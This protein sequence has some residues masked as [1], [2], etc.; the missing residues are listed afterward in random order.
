MTVDFSHD[1]GRRF[2][3]KAGAAAAL[4]L[5]FSLNAYAAKGGVSRSLKGNPDLESWIRIDEQG[6]V[7]IFTGKIELGQGIGTALVQIAADELDVDVGKISLITP[8]TD[9][10]PDERYTVGS[11]SIQQSGM[12]MRQASAVARA[13]L[14]DWAAEDLK[15]SASKLSIS[16]GVISSGSRK[17][18][19]GELVAARGQ[20]TGN[21]LQSAPVKKPADRT[22]SGTSMQRRDIPGKIFAEGVYI[23]DLR[24]P[25]MMHARVVRPATAGSHLKSLDKAAV[26]KMPGVVKIVQD[27]SFLAVIA[28]R[29]EQAIAA[30]EHLAEMAQWS[31]PP[32]L[33]DQTSLENFILTHPQA[34]RKILTDTLTDKGQGAFKAEHEARYFR[35]YQAHASMGPSI[36]LAHME[37]GR[38]TV[39]SHTQ[40]PYP[41]RKEISNFLSLPEEK[42]RVIHKDGAGCYGHNAADDA[43]LEAAILAYEMPGTPI[44]LQWMRGEEFRWEPYGSAMVMEVKAALNKDGSIKN[45]DYNVHGFPHSTRPF[46]SG[47]RL[48][49]TRYVAGNRKVTPPRE[50][51]QPAGGLDRNA[52]PYYDF[53]HQKVTKN[54]IKNS[55]LRTSALRALGGY[56]NV[57]AVESFMDELA[58]QTGQDPVQFRLRHLKDPR[59]RAVV[60]KAAEMANWQHS[61]PPAGAGRGFAFSRYKNLGGYLAVC[62]DLSVDAKNGEITVSDIYAAVDCGEIINP[63]GVLNQVEGGLLQSLSWSLYE[64]VNFEAQEITSEDWV[65]YPILTYDRLPKLQV[66]LMDLPDAPPLGAG[67]VAQ[68]PMSAALANALYQ[69]TG[70][71][72]RNLPLS[73]EKNRKK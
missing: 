9:I 21:A 61:A 42:V 48:L 41:L 31:R 34:Q 40:G 69:A 29:E 46:G 25:G 15:I 66:H 1:M 71:R 7:T 11:Q 67:E 2:L 54:F 65:S 53:A 4:T 57:F 30:A 14:L 5:H 13:M 63:D 20:I 68:G 24:L 37:N 8:D 16:N 58:H 23:H 52:V 60:T 17:I 38:L 45:W 72:L 50:I 6:F 39:W 28:Q 19:Y 35:P 36:G 12:A 27:G 55:P 18:S 73:R 49:A 32:D 44:R 43:A 64:Q 22:V 56:A 26:L 10:T 70:K 33:P 51:P 59:A 47:G 62:V 3:L